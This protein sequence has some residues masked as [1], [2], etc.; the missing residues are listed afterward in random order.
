MSGKTRHT[1][2]SPE[3][4][5]D[6]DD[7]PMTQSSVHKSPIPDHLWAGHEDAF[8]F[9]A[10]T[11]EFGGTTTLRMR[12]GAIVYRQGEP[13]TSLFYLQ[14]G[15]I[16]INVVSPHGKE[17]IMAILAD[18][19][20]FG[21]T[22]LLGESARPASATCHTDCILIRVEKANATAALLC[23]VSFGEFLVARSLRRVARL[24]RRLISQLFDSSE[25]R[26]A[27]ILLTLA[28]YG[29]GGWQGRTIDK[30]DQEDLAQMVGTTRAR[31][32]HFMNKFRRL[33]HIDYDGRLVV[34][35]SLANIIAH[36]GSTAGF[37]N[38]ED[39]TAETD[40]F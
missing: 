32:S 24:R 11:A 22:C 39:A 4:G 19:T 13:P 36:D 21:E 30:V 16:R 23:S 1:A 14:Q 25:Q 37:G 6:T 28:N 12:A 27:R 29:Q 15:H 20:V 2:F 5:S 35:R 40:V 31:V 9:A 3:L 26:L 38:S 33:G 34:Y 7:D 17:A 10:F 18:D 8:D